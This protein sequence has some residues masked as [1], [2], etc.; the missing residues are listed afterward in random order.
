MTARKAC[1]EVLSWLSFAV[2]R[3]LAIFIM[4]IDTRP[5]ATVPC[6]WR[7]NLGRFRLLYY[8][9]GITVVHFVVA[10]W[11]TNCAAAERTGQESEE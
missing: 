5:L 11:L 7:A 6:W 9:A 2:R 3:E 1:E 10:D 4:I 8:C